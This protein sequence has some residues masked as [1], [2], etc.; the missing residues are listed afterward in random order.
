MRDRDSDRDRSR[1]RDRDDGDRFDRRWR[2]VKRLFDLEEIGY[3]D[4]KNVDLLSKAL[5]PQGKLMSRRRTG[6]DAKTQHR[7][8][9]AI[10]RARFMALIPYGV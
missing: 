7:L 5:S 2:P 6:A 3:I 8:R 10:L 9:K 4:Y 1:D